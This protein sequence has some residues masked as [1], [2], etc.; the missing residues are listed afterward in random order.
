MELYSNIEIWIKYNTTKLNW[1]FYLRKKKLS[2]YKGLLRETR[3][4]TSR[5][6]PVESVGG[7]NSSEEVWLIRMPKFY[8]LKIFNSLCFNHQ[9]TS[10]VVGFP[11]YLNTDIDILTGETDIL[12]YTILEF[13]SIL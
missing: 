2:L 6:S 8:S 13:P 7:Q 4:L 9:M 1:V 11:T 5:W 10:L 3:E 12:E